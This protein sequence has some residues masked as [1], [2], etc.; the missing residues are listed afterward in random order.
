MGSL[1]LVSFVVA[2][3]GAMG[4]TGLFALATHPSAPLG[5]H[6]EA[7]PAYPP[8]LGGLAVLLATVVSIWMLGISSPTRHL[9]LGMSLIFGAGLLGDLAQQ[10]PYALIA[11]AVITLFVASAGGLEVAAL[12]DLTFPGLGLAAAV[13]AMMSVTRAINALAELPGFR[14]TYTFVALTWFV[15][16][17]AMSGHDLAFR[18]AIVLQ[19][20]IGGYIVCNFVLLGRPFRH[21]FL[22]SSGGLMIAFAVGWLALVLTQGPA[23]TFPTY[24]AL[25]VLY[26]P[27]ADW[28]SVLLRRILRREDLFERSD[29]HL[30][31]YLKL[32]G[33]RTGQVFAVMLLVSG[34]CALF[35]FAGW[36][37]GWPPVLMYGLALLLFGLYHA[38]ITRAWKRVSGFVVFTQ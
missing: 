27:L 9:V 26:L 33:M 30:H 24:A 13:I 31:H 28:C 6:V 17:A 8:L 11:Q 14:A 38:W 3:G 18:V 10:R 37:H 12:S 16:A 25:W 21:V 2:F 34:L 15:L 23:G 4:C 35:G 36:R 5:F 32:H 20:A 22:G 19:S 1:W 7:N 29:R